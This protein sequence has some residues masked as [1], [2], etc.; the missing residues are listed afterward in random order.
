MYTDCTS[1]TMSTMRIQ[2]KY[3]RIK[4]VTVRA[5]TAYI[6]LYIRHIKRS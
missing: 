2:N 5:E 6:K 1:L 3:T 4:Q